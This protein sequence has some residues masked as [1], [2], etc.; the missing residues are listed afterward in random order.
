MTTQTKTKRQ[1]LAEV[2]RLEKFSYNCTS[3][4][5]Y[6][7]AIYALGQLGENPE[8]GADER[9]AAIDAIRRIES[10]LNLANEWDVEAQAQVKPAIAKLTAKPAQG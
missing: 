9:Q 1:R 5:N 7:R 8:F 10:G 4:E 3:I 2:K 6:R